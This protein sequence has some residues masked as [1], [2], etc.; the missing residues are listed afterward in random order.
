MYL[1]NNLKNP[2]PVIVVAPG[3]N[4]DI[5]SFKY[6]ARH[7]ASYGFGIIAINFP[8]TDAQRM[9]N[10][11]AGL[12]TIPRPNAWLQ[13]PQ[14]VTLVLN[15]VEQKVKSDPLWQGTLGLNNV[16]MLGQSLG[17]YTSLGIGGS[18]TAWDN[19]LKSCQEVKD[20]YYL[21][22]NPALIWQCRGVNGMPPIKNMQDK[23]IKA[24]IAINPVTN[25]IYNE[26]SM[27]SIKTP[28][29]MI[30]GSADIFA[31]AIPEQIRPF[32]WLTQ[33]DKYLLLVGN[34]THLSFLEGTNNLPPIIV[35][36]DPALARFYLQVL[37]LAFFNTYLKNQTEFQLYLIRLCLLLISPNP[38]LTCNCNLGLTKTLQDC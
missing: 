9:W 38:R 29:L 35:G 27:G 17:G 24:V 15:A 26:Q 16:G 2:A 37:S 7:L 8:Q 5:G 28:I 1:P 13:Q 12:D 23:R 19:V 31:P 36:P 21:T 10:V 3:L 34:S 6:A 33:T 32:T 30:S 14:D 20:P 18:Q 11:V 25:P 4:S 22:F